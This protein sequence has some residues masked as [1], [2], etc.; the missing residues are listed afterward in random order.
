M[1]HADNP[2]IAI[3]V[4]L[5]SVT[6]MAFAD[7]LIKW[8]S[9][10]FSVWHVFLVRSLFGL[11][12]LLLVTRA[13][14]AP[15]RGNTAWVW[16]RSV[17]LV[18]CWLAFYAALPTLDLS[19]AAVVV[20]TNP[21]ITTLLAATILREPI[22]RHHIAAVALGFLG[23]LVIIRPG[24]DAVSGA[25]L[26]PLAAAVFY[27]AAMI[28]T[29]TRC[30]SENPF[31]L[32]IALHTTFIAVG[33]LGLITLSGVALPTELNASTQFL[34]TG[35]SPMT[36]FQWGVM[37]LLGVLSA[38]YFAGVAYAYQR[39]KP[40]TLAT[41][42]YGYLPSAALWGLVLFGEQPDALTVVGMVL[43]TLAGV[44]VTRAP[45]PSA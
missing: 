38:G 39:A 42:D 13:L 30:R 23:V 12:C 9:A 24:T 20:Y 3:T 26:L 22:T 15:L 27:S 37:A 10:D 1:A 33:A 44:L 35:W 40:H 6:A 8:I 2:R 21:I 16:I 43:I 34:L 32:G 31:T 14:G 17:L 4:L 36:V 28:L 25:V 45:D 41:F 5:L 19:V 7:A 11:P 18:L 29:R